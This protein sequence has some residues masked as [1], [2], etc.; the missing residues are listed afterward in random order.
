MW[1]KIPYDVYHDYYKNSLYRL[2]WNSTMKMF[3]T[4]NEKEHDLDEGLLKYKVTFIDVPFVDKDDVKEMGAKWSS[5][6]KCWYYLGDNE[7]KGFFSKY[8]VVQET[9]LRA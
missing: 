7:N 4:L 3:E 2:K 5:E 9:L 6:Y 1:F 8:R